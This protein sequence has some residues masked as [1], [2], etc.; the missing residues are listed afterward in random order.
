MPELPEVETVKETLNHLVAGKTL[1]KIEVGWPKMIKRPD[2][3]EAFVMMLAG[4]K[5]HR[6]AR[7]GKFLSFV[8]DDYVMVSHL[9]MEGRYEMAAG[10]EPDKHTH[11]RFHFTDGSELRY[12][13]VRKFGTMHIFNPGEEQTSLPLSQLGPEPVND[14]SFTTTYLK[15]I[16]AKTSRTVKT[17]L[18]DQRA[19][20]GL[21]NIYVDE[22]LF[23]SGIM[24]NKKASLLNTKQIQSLH[25][26]IMATIAEAIASGG[27]SV[28]SYV[29][30][31]G[32][33]GMFQN[34]LYV[35]ARRDE[36]CKNCGTPIEKMIE[37]GRGTHYC[38]SCQV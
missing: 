12:R 6:V 36:P 8:L 7:R 24:P 2:D 21:G 5:I 23:R 38:P 16:F 30:G 37:A 32:E 33:M 11:V 17:V 22:S 18:L 29:N 9:R 31:Q 14:S 35:Y 34:Q 28:R 19:I 27:S 15:E 1:E 20:A 3:A 10:S 25:K 4:Q 13:D 26:E